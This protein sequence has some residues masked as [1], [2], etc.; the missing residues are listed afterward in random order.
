MAKKEKTI[1]DLGIHET[2]TVEEVIGE[3]EINGKKE[4]IVKKYEVTKVA[5]GW[6]YAFDYPNFRQSP[7]V[8]VPFHNEFQK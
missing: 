6:V 8:F 7:I 5:G 2:L 1:Y 3:Q 4:D